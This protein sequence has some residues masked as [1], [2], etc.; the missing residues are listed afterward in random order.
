MKILFK[1]IVAVGLALTFVQHANASTTCQPTAYGPL[2]ISQVSFSQFAQQAYQPQ[3]QTEWCWAASISMMFAY[4]GYQ[5]A[6]PA[7]VTEAY[8]TI[9][10]V[11]A[12]GVVMAQALNRTWKDGTGNVFTAKLSGLYDAQAG[13]DTLDNMQLINELDQ[14]RPFV[15][16]TGGHAVV[17]TAIEYYNTMYGPQIQA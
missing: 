9:A 2:C 5:V 10:N 14:N 8:G 12:P 7:I 11:P 3:Q 16:G 6:Q 17:V 1:L 15:I 13:L 4:Y